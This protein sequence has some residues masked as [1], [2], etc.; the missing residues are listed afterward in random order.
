MHKTKY[1]HFQAAYKIFRHLKSNLGIGIHYK[2]YDTLQ[3]EGYPDANHEESPM[4]KRSTIGCHTFLGGN[5]GG[6]LIKWKSKK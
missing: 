5:L 4:D 2:K 1:S 3:I 6:N